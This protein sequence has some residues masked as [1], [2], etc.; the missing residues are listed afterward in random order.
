MD[1]VKIL[2]NAK[3]VD[4]SANNNDT[5]KYSSRYGHVDVV[6]ILLNDKRVDPSANNNDTMV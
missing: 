3:R 5:I 2:L 4:P 1:V 6:K